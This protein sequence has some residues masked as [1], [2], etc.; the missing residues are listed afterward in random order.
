MRHK[1]YSV[2]FQ[3]GG[4]R[5][6]END[7]LQMIRSAQQGDALSR[8]RIIQHFKPFVLNVCSRATKRYLTWSD[9]ES[10]V[11]LTS[12]NKAIDHFDPNANKKFIYFSQMIITRDL[13]DYYRK[14]HRHHHL[15]LD[16]EMRIGDDLDIA[17]TTTY[18][19]MEAE[20]QFSIQEEQALLVQEILIYSEVLK[21]YGLQFSELPD[22]SPK[23]QDTRDNCFKLARIVKDQED[24][25]HH[26]LTKKRLPIKELSR[27]A[28]IPSKTIEKNRKYI[29]AVTIC[30][31]H[32]DLQRIQQYIERGGNQQ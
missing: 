21:E 23:H 32:S 7:I 11:G 27:Y 8:E 6:D 13:I 25:K 20:K 14:E 4:V 18:E 17:E 5:L 26:L 3:E 12:L 30:L 1:E 19:M 2:C 31:L 9:E 24:L 22:S 15:S 28:Q 16:E 29:I 10:S